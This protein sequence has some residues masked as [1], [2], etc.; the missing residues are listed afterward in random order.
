MISSLEI[1][2][3]KSDIRKRNLLIV[4][5]ML[6]FILMGTVVYFYFQKQMLKSKPEKELTRTYNLLRK[7]NVYD[8]LKIST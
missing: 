1:E 8:L 2:N 3:Q 7:M 6:F 4:S 5:G